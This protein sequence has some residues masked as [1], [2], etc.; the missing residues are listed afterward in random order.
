MPAICVYIAAS[1]RDARFTRICVA[2]VRY[3]HPHVPIK[4]LVGGALQRGLAEELHR[5]W[6]VDVM[7]LPAGDYGWGFVKLEPLFGQSGERFLM[8]DSDTAITGPILQEW[9]DSTAPFI[10]DNEEYSEAGIRSRYYDWQKVQKIDPD[11]RAPA[12]VFNSGQWVGTSGVLA[13]EDFGAFMDWSFPRQLQAQD[14]FFPGDQGIMNY[15]LNK[16]VREGKL[17]VERRSIMHWPGHGMSGYD[18][19]TV[20]ERKAASKIVH[21][22][23]MKRVTLRSMPGTD[24][25]EFFERAYYQRI[26][27]GGLRRRVAALGHI[28]SYWLYELKLRILLRKKIVAH[29]ISALRGK[30]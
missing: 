23:G 20:A 9:E 16:K 13:R 18:A 26:P 10:V 25:L 1:T 11:A 17:H 22:A 27:G 19:R 29:Q 2:S 7:Q 8:L 4:L 5:Y 14:V 21:W 6:N 12:F 30:A 3:F 28:V 15:V 24:L